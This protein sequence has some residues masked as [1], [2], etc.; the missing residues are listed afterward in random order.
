[1]PGLY[2]QLDLHAVDDQVLSLFLLR[3]NVVPVVLVSFR[4]CLL[5]LA[6]TL[7]ACRSVRFA[8]SHR[9]RIWF[10]LSLANGIWFGFYNLILGDR[11]FGRSV[12]GLI[13]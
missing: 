1:M 8:F 4:N 13:N 9:G 11:F 5:T 10:V 2:V 12:F 3:K 7:L 6:H